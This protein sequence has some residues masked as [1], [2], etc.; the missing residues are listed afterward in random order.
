MTEYVLA[1]S[2]NRPQAKAVS[3]W[4]LLLNPAS[5]PRAENVFKA[6][7]GHFVSQKASFE[8]GCQEYEAEN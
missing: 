4:R 7:P 5:N 3:L 8:E 2:G 6:L 1:Q